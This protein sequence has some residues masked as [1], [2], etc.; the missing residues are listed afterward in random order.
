M[1][2]D[3]V[4]RIAEPE[5]LLVETDVYS[6]FVKGSAAE[7]FALCLETGSGTHFVRSLVTGAAASTMR[8]GVIW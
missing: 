1:G 2:D 4:Y 6:L 7:R 8:I 5:A 3:K